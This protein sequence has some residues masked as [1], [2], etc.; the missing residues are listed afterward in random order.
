M[1]KMKSPTQ[2]SD[3]NNPKLRVTLRDVAKQAG[4]SHST[5]SLCFRN[6]PSI[7]EKR[8]QQVLRVAEQMGYRPDPV[9]S[10]LAEYRNR[11]RPQT[12]QS[13][14]VW[15]NYW[16]QPEK[17]R[18]YREFDHYWRGAFQ[19]AESFGYRLE[20][21]RWE[22]D[23]SA[24]RFE[25]I[26]LTRNIRGLLI[27]PHETVPDWGDFDW[28]KFSIIRFGMSVRKPDS[29]LVTADQQRAVLMAFEK[30]K[31][32]GY[33]RIGLVTGRDYD[34]KLGGNFIGG[35][36][37]AQEL[38]DFRHTL[39]PLLTDERIYLE[40]RT[41]AKRALE[42]WLKKHRPDAILTTEILVPELIRELGLR[43][44]EDVAVAGTSIDVPVDAG[45]NQNP[46]DIG[47]IA[48]EMLVALIKMNVCGEPASPCR[49]LMESHW[50]D[51]KS[52]PPRS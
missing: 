3:S 6:H 8:R 10:S 36:A 45:I 39:P 22:A 40:N 35:L 43:I 1:A 34:S 28:S 19:A 18:K 2:P 20:E 5:V 41:M 4:V 16:E 26:L 24:R 30:I 12:I 7:P 33:Q 47:R 13:A 25:Q 27:P 9:L 46:E 14:L 44:P 37:A 23:C 11:N 52:L 31:Q 15:I 38:F 49:I 21:M 29:N 42:R 17:L 51:G 32:Y 48:V 50:H